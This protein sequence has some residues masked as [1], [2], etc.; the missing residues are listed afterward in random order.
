MDAS[1]FA[2]NIID[3]NGTY[4]QETINLRTVSDIK[5]NITRTLVS[6]PNVGQVDFS[7]TATEGAKIV[8]DT[9]QMSQSMQDF[10]TANSGGT[11]AVSG[12]DADLFR[13]DPKQAS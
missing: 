12:V 4:H 13:V 3:D 9:N 6:E 7:L 5:G 8:V 2:I 10:I 1:S 11:F